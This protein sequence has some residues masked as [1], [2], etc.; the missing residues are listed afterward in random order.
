[1]H[2]QMKLVYFSG[3]LLTCLFL[4]GACSKSLAETSIVLNLT[5]LDNGNTVVAHPGNTIIIN[6]DENPSTGYQWDNETQTK[7]LTLTSAE[8]VP[9]PTPI[10]GAGGKRVYT[11]KVNQTGTGDIQL[12]Y[13]RSSEGTTGDTKHFTVT[14]QVTKLT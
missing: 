13:W 8:F 1:M 9:P 11:F 14:I 7:I 2:K 5:E 6:L 3:V 10:P 4:L 12:K